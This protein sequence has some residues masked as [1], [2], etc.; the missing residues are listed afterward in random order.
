M[1]DI[2]KSNTIYRKSIQI[3]KN[4]QLKNGG[5]LATPKGERYPYVYP[6]D[7][8]ICVLGFVSAG[9]FKEAKIALKFILGRQLASGAFPQRLDTTG[10]DASYKPIQID[11]TAMTIYSLVQYVKATE[12]TKFALAHLDVVEKAIGY[13]KH[14]FY[15]EKGLVYTPNSVHEF[16]PRE[17]GF[18]I[19]ANA[20]CCA[21]LKESVDLAKLIYTNTHDWFEVSNLIKAGILKYMWNSRMKIFVKTIRIKESSSVVASVDVSPYALA[22]FGVLDDRDDKIKKTIKDIEKKLWD[23]QL[24][25]ICRYPKHIGRNNGGWGPWPHFT[26]MIARHFIRLKNRTKADKYINW[27]NKISYN[28]LLPE[29]I[30]TV[31]EF[32]EY[33]TDFTESGL[34]RKDRLIMINN[35]KKHPTFKKGIAYITLPLAWPHAEYIRT[36][37]LYKETFMS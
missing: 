10:K 11:G 29:H 13:I 12:D 5:C 26:L 9:L 2:K 28:N 21:A 27:V 31:K 20:I 15:D 19:W 30:S 4:V 8:A 14:N 24:G 3:L 23:K 6:R 36:L 34:L 25:G 37:N 35:A 17:A 18:E 32:D 1:I 16:P 22:D 33:I 7:H